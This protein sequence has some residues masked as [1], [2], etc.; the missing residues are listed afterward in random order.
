MANLDATYDEA[1]ALSD[2]GDVE[3][4]VK[5]LEELVREAPDHALAHNALSVL[6][7]RLDRMDEAVAHAQRVCELEPNDAFSFIALSLICQKAGLIMEA[8]QA[9]MAARQIQFSGE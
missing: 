6:C 2:Q 3:A 8:E 4:A 7:G 1:L 9:S 5:K